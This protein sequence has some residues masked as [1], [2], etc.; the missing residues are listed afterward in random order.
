M[1][2]SVCLAAA[3]DEHLMWVPLLMKPAACQP[4]GSYFLPPCLPTCLVWGPV[5]D[6]TKEAPEVVNLYLWHQ[7][8]ELEDFCWSVLGPH[9]HPL[10]GFRLPCV[11]SREYQGVGRE[12]WIWSQ[13]MLLRIGVFCLVLRSLPHPHPPSV[14]ELTGWARIQKWRSHLTQI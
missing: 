12:W 8:A 9:W 7:E 1:Q 10:L 6:F 2:W 13:L 3:R 4:V 11:S 5:S 14:R